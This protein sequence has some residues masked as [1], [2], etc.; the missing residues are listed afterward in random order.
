MVANKG[1]AIKFKAGYTLG[2]QQEPKRGVLRSQTSP[3]SALNKYV[4]NTYSNLVVAASAK[5]RLGSKTADKLWNLNVVL[6]Y[7]PEVDIETF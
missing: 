6:Q 4:K 5:A 1:L 3:D 7:F 2:W